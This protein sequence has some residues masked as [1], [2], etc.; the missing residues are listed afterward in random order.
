MVTK[1]VRRLIVGFI[2]TGLAALA[3]EPSLTVY[4]APNTHGTVSGW[5]VDF[6]S[7]R[8][9]VVNNYLNHMDRVATDANYAMAFSEVPNLMVLM[10]FTP[11]GMAQLQQQVKDGRTELVNGFF[12]EPSISLSGGEARQLFYRPSTDK[13][14]RAE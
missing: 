10:Q 7:E 9:H 11:P 6:D 1:M 13:M 8:S 4:L 2:L 14:F 5:L 12:L 3:A